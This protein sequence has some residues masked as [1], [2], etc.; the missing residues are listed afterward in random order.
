MAALRPFLENLS[1]AEFSSDG[2]IL[3]CVVEEISRQGVNQTMSW[4]L[5]T[6]S[7]LSRGNDLCTG[8]TMKVSNKWDREAQAMFSLM[9]KGM[10]LK[11]KG[12]LLLSKQL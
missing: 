1:E 5:P 12:R 6:A 2:L 11:L 3:I 9:G 4:Q 7:R 8:S 10:S